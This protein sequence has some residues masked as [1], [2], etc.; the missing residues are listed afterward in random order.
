MEDRIRMSLF[1]LAGHLGKT[2]TE[3]EDMPYS[4]LLEWFAF[5]NIEAKQYG[6]SSPENHNHRR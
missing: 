6:N 2:V 5:F 1:R 4:E 3:L